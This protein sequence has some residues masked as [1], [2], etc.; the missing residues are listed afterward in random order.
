MSLTRRQLLTAAAALACPMP[1]LAQSGR[2]STIIVGYPVGGSLDAM[3][4]SIAHSLSVVRGTPVVVDNKPGFSGN[5]GAQF[6]ARAKPDGQTLLMEPLTTYAINAS[7]MGKAT[8]YDVLKSFE[9]VAIVGNLQNV[10]ITPIGLEAD[11]LKGFIELARSKPGKL[12]YATTGNGSLEHVAGEMFRQAAGI[13][14]FP[15]PYKGSAPGVTDLI[16]GEI[17]AMFVNTS[18]AINNLRT[19]RIKAL[20]IAGPRRVAVMPDVPTFTESGVRLRKDP[21][22]IFGLA[23]PKGTPEDARQKLNAD[24]NGAMSDAEVRERFE[25]LGIEIVTL[26]EAQV[27]DIVEKEVA[28][29]VEVIKE[30]GIKAS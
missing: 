15:V 10:L 29:W 2:E 27:T 18:T 26:S 19:G 17:Q 21:V 3:A 14:I 8:G 22:S 16:A 25:A 28:S 24:I 9:H 20:G 30:T 1:L 11:D 4:R 12:S 5:I 6:V 7:L 13:D 23:V